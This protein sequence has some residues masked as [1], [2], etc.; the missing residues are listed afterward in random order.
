MAEARQNETKDREMLDSTR[1]FVLGESELVLGSCQGETSSLWMSR[2]VRYPSGM[3]STVCQ[4]CT[5]VVA[6]VSVKVISDQL[7][8][9]TISF[10]LERYSRASEHP[11]RGSGPSRA[12]ING[13]K[14]RVPQ[15]RP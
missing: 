5:P 3:W 15:G 4:L 2:R 10:T 1:N 13:I 6:G 11:E 14:Q 7:G 12:A 9:A 8:H